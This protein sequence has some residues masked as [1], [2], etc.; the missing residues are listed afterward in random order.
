MVHSLVLQTAALVSS[1]LLASVAAKSGFTGLE[2]VALT[3]PSNS[4]AQITLFGAHVISFRT[5]Y[6]PL[7]DALFISKKSNIDGVKPIRG[8]M[9]FGFPNFAGPVNFDAPGHGVVQIAMWTVVS[10]QVATEL[11]KEIDASF[12]LEG[13]DVTRKMW[14]FDFV[15]EY[16]V[17]LWTTWLET[18]L[19]VHNVNPIAVEFQALFHN[20]IHVNN[21]VKD[22]LQNLGLTESRLL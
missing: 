18:T 7:R 8:G 3:H 17:K 10:V 14:P 1:A 11:C 21:V 2:T 19:I 9:P 22:G 12:R 16:E 13:I 4:S 6:D 5:T 20:Y 15:L